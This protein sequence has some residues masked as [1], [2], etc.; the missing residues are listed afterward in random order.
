M[1]IVVSA[2]LVILLSAGCRN[3]DRIPDVSRIQV[4]LPV[5][6]F[7]KDFFSMDL[8]HLPQALD[9][10]SRKHPGFTTDYLSLILGYESAD[11]ALRYIPMFI[12]DSLY[13]QLYEDASKKFASFDVPK[14]QVARG[15]QF[16]KYYFPK[17]EVPN[18]IVT[19]IGPVDG[20]ATGISGDHRFA[21]GLQGY[22]GKNYPAY[23][24]SYIMSV[25][26]A[27]K[28]RK[29]EPEYIPVNCITSVIDDLYPA[30]MAGKPLIE[31]MVE[32]GK[33]MYLLDKF[34][35]ETADTLKTGY[36]KAQLDGAYD[37]ESSIWSYFISNNLLYTTDPITV[38]D[39][40]NEGPNTAALGPA[41][42]GFIGQ[43][44]GWQIVK[45]WMAANKKSLEEMLR[46][47]AK[48]IFE[49]AKYK[50]S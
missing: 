11:T 17:Y 37:H 19:F 44:V 30:K 9:D 35:P 1:K 8:Q 50:P 29:F 16:V 7:E 49:E 26:P 25:Y 4:Q 45:K 14:Q 21:I 27:Y 43:F 34:L 31:Q 32:A 12:Q 13:H 22:M 24:T 10:L 23:Q 2:V 46:T 18:G 15:L 36:T 39:Y 6:R 48:Q 41:S 42:P 20:I 28:S 47:P 40:M 5:S 3:E 33:R 38:R